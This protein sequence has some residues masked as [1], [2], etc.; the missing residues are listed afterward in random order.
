MSQQT[1]DIFYRALLTKDRRFDGRI[2]FAVT[3]T[4]IY[5]RPICPARTPLRKNVTFF[6]SAAAAEEAGFRPCL[7]CRPETSPGT[8]AWI[9]TSTTVSR[10]L[11]LIAGGIVEQEGIPGLSER[12]GVGERQLRRLFFEHIGAPPQAVVRTRRLDF[13][14]KL[15]DE[16]DLSISQIAFASGFGSIRRFND[17]FKLRFQRSPADVRKSRTPMAT[18]SLCLTLK[19]P[20][21]PPL[22]WPS[23]LG[24]LS[25]R[26][27]PGVEAIADDTY[28]RTFELGGAA[29]W[30]SVRPLPVDPA[31]E[32]TA[33]G[34][35]PD[36]L[37]DVV[38]RVRGLFDLEAD[39]LTIAEQLTQDD[40]L[41]P[42][43]RK[44]PG[45]RVPGTWDGFELGVRA[46]LGQQVSVRGART[47]A[48]RLARVCGLAIT[49]EDHPSLRYV[50]PSP[51]QIAAAADL[52]QIG[53]PR[54]RAQTIKRLA[55]LVRS[56][57]LRLDASADP[58]ETVAKL[59]SIPGIGPWTAEYIAMRALRHPDAFPESDL[60][61]GRELRR[62][63][64]EEA[65]EAWRPWRAYAVMSLWK[66]AAA[67]NAAERKK[68]NV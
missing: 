15:V 23:L 22:D 44:H 46:I 9:G 57:E 45:L 31:L 60:V 2:F 36:Y 43:L 42:V 51:S 59:L 5:C 49:V 63:G 25:D 47:L 6:A 12:V 11:R 10:A 35:K 28:H 39:P 37:M 29:G 48:E 56:G 21:R 30:L 34:C 54:M 58:E 64:L 24:F 26:A 68:A 7:R 3:T 41:R 65:P 40:R 14:R 38:G 62:M 13:A 55:E 32:L 19:L 4:G 61:I 67:R 8:P 17:A 53:V 66:G 16:T 33:R 18:G 52:E 27:I 1:P 50:F 20:Y